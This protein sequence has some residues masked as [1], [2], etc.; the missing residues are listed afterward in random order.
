MFKVAFS[1]ALFLILCGRTF[2]P[3]DRTNCPDLSRAFLRCL[4]DVLGSP[5][6]SVKFH[7]LLNNSAICTES[8]KGVLV[9]KGVPADIRYHEYLLARAERKTKSCKI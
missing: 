4:Q 5:D 9:R 8:Q 2:L 1:I 7:G 6:V 3:L